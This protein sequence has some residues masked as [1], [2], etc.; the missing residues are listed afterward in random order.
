LIDRDRRPE[1]DIIHG[2][3]VNLWIQKPK[4]IKSMTAWYRVRGLRS[5]IMFRNRLLLN[6]CLLITILG[7]LLLVVLMVGGEGA[8]EKQASSV[9]LYMREPGDDGRFTQLVAAGEDDTVTFELKLENYK[10]SDDEDRAV[11][12]YVLPDVK[13]GDEENWEFEF[14]DAENWGLPVFTG[15]H[16]D[17]GTVDFYK[18]VVS[19]NGTQTNVTFEVSH[20]YEVIADNADDMEYLIRGLDYEAED[21]PTEPYE[22]LTLR[23]SKERFWRKIIQRDGGTNH[24]I[25]YLMDDGETPN[26]ELSTAE[27]LRAFVFVPPPPPPSLIVNKESIYLVADEMNSEV[28]ATLGNRGSQKD[29]FK[30]LV[31]FDDPTALLWNISAQPPPQLDTWYPLEAVEEEAI[32]LLISLKEPT[33]HN[34]VPSRSYGLKL[35][36]ESRVSGYTYEAF[37]ETFGGQWKRCSF[38][39]NLLQRY[40]PQIYLDPTDTDDKLINTDGSP[41]SFKFKLKNTGTLTD[42]ISL[43]AEVQNIESRAGDTNDDW[44]KSF[45]P[46]SP[47]TLEPGETIDVLVNL[48]PELDNDKIPPGKYPVYV[49]ITSINNLARTDHSMVYLRMANLYNPGWPP[50]PDPPKKIWVGTTGAYT[51]MVRNS[52]QADDTFTLNFTIRNSYGTLVAS[53]EA[54]GGWVYTFKDADTGRTFEN[55]QF[56]LAADGSVNASLEL[57][58]PVGLPLG[59]YDLDISITSAGPPQTMESIP[60]A[61]FVVILPDLWIGPDDIVF[62]PHNADENQEVTLWATAHLKGGVSA[63]VRIGLYYSTPDGFTLVEEK[64]LDFKG[65]SGKKGIQTVNF[66]WKCERPY[67]KMKNLKVV[68]DAGNNIA[69]EKEDNNEVMVTLTVRELPGQVEKHHLSSGS[70][71]LM[72]TIA[73]L[74]ALLAVVVRVPAG[75]F[76]AKPERKRRTTRRRR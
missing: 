61:T 16:P 11:L 19:G 73:L 8:A 30:L 28:I 35:T 39:I 71:F 42:T 12:L 70:Q 50:P 5:E 53:D 47:I 75:R 34:N 23:E 60:T 37:I 18:Y 14:T 56:S 48:T 55:N 46:V 64:E 20:D 33:D 57:T 7:V 62:F 21:E 36:M 69:E 76:Q 27:E 26:I 51:F 74:L 3:P 52:G 2:S 59:D 29:E 9:G 15:D 72:A 66:S 41:T 17:F 22:N 24:N 45:Y 6:S 38:V 4:L 54:P 40:D 44:T 31:E 13:H 58:P 25:T 63:T 43:K 49:N 1:W 68:L 10:G 65:E 67:A 32:T